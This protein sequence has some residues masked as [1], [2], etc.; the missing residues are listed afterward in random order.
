M[1]LLVCDGALDEPAEVE[2]EALAGGVVDLH[3]EVAPLGRLGAAARLED[4]D[5]GRHA[6]DDRAAGDVEATDVGDDLELAVLEL[7]PLDRLLGGEAVELGLDAIVDRLHV[8]RF[9]EDDVDL[10]ADRAGADETGGG[11]AGL[12]QRGD[13]LGID[14]LGERRDVAG[15]TG[16]AD[17]AAR[18]LLED[19][20]DREA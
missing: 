7:A 5:V 16:E 19:V 20:D 12:R 9:V 10:G 17:G 3:A 18:R 8:E 2:A 11:D 4:V 6:V 14:D 1:R 15:E 13:R